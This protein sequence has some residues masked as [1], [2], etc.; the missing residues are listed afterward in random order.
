MQSKIQENLNQFISVNP[1]VVFT[2]NRNSDF[3]LININH[4]NFIGRTWLQKIILEQPK[5]Q[6]PVSIE[7]LVKLF[8]T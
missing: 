2:D 8:S 1:I 6:Y 5:Y 3:K 7:E 4:V